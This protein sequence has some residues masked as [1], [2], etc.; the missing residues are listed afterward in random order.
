MKA[1]N[2]LSHERDTLLGT[3]HLSASSVVQRTLREHSTTDSGYA[4]FPNKILMIVYKLIPSLRNITN[5]FCSWS[6]FSVYSLYCIEQKGY[7]TWADHY[8]ARCE[9]SWVTPGIFER[10]PE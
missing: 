3:I 1:E 6:L 10:K 8:P 9:K 4:E 7:A 2:D 5:L